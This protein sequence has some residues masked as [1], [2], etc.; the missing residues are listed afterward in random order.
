MRRYIL[1]IDQGTTS[2]RAVLFN[3]QGA[4]VA[5]GQKELTQYYPNPG[6][7][8]HDAEEI[9]QHTMEVIRQA[10]DTAGI[11]PDNIAGI[12]IT[13]QRETTVVWDK[14]TGKPICPAIVW[15]CRRTSD[16]AAMLKQGEDGRKIYQKTGLVP[17]AYF[18]ATKLEWILQNVEGAREKAEG[19][20]L[21]FGTIDCWLLYKL[22][23]GKVHATDYTNAARTMFFNIHEGCWDKKLLELFHI[24]ESM[25]PEVKESS[26]IFGTATV[27][28]GNVPVCGIAGDQQAGLFGQGCF[29]DGDVKNTYGTGC[30]LLMNTGEKPVHTEDGLLTTIAMA[31]NGKITYALEGSVFIGGAVVQWLRDEM[32]LISTAAETEKRAL[33]VA[34]SC[35]VYVVP[36]FTGLGAPHWDMYARGAI[37]GITRGAGADHIIRAALESIAYQVEDLLGAMKNASDLSC[38]ELK[39]DGGASANDF[40]LQ[41]QASI[42]DISVLRP[43]IIETTVR[44]V[45][46]LAGL[47]VKFWKND[48]Q[49]L[50]LILEDKHFESAM[51]E[52]QRTKLLSGW[53]KAVERAKQWEN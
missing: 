32:H 26:G 40:L 23:E 18:S 39:V 7:V 24:P 5:S 30:F 35:G 27:L 53:H 46:F 29:H 43:K 9:W 10:I 12:G 2:T 20:Q 15:Q 51:K 28:E 25:L 6:W 38:K 17:D 11:T 8:E 52:E 49:I 47:A 36:A 13:N 22:T 1:A 19:G 31:R 45:A 37:L 42:S 21:L 33:S 14:T 44:G 16:R 41:F 34:D 4:I 48:E 50:S 3:K